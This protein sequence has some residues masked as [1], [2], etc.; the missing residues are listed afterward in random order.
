MTLVHFFVFEDLVVTF[1]ERGY[2]TKSWVIF[3]AN[4]PVRT[5][6]KT[7]KVTSDVLSMLIT[8]LIKTISS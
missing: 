5:T 2:I 8:S 6:F 1:L 3:R 7:V 4:N